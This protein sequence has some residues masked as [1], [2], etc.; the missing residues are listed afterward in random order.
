MGDSLLIEDYE[1][2]LHGDFG[3]NGSKGNT[4]SFSRV[5]RKMVHA[6]T[7]SP[8]IHNNVTAVGVTCLLYQ[9]YNRKGLS[10]WAHAHSAIHPN[11]KNQLLVFGDDYTLSGLI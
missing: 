2:A 8:K 11:G 5:N 6:H 4:K 9:Y 10:S 3:T 1:C 7:H